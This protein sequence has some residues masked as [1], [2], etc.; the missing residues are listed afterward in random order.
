MSSSL[1]F[2]LLTVYQS[3][4]QLRAIDWAPTLT[5]ACV[6]LGKLLSLSDLIFTIGIIW[7]SLNGL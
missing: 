1:V 5:Q 6:T 3:G 4:I 7:Y 2:P